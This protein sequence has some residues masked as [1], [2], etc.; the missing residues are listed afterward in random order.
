MRFMEIDGY[1]YIHPWFM[2]ID[3]FRVF[4]DPLIS[5]RSLDK[6][7]KRFR[8]YKNLDDFYK[9]SYNF[10]VFKELQKWCLRMSSSS[11]DK[12]EDYKKAMY[13]VLSVL[14]SIKPLV[15]SKYRKK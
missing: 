1:H 12:S 11:A 7:Y 10:F 2:M 4:T 15:V 8:S 6:Y 3:I 13:D 14:K 9:I 5:Y